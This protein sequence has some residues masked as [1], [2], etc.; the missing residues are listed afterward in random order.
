M[1]E[2]IPTE[3]WF[4]VEGLMPERTAVLDEFETWL[5]GT[6]VDAGELDEESAGFATAA[7]G[8]GLLGARPDADAAEPLANGVANV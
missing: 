5:G 4:S 7:D 8:D 1:V 3:G 6:E 2:L